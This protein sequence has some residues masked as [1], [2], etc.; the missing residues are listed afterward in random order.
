MEQKNTH[1]LTYGS[2]VLIYGNLF[3]DNKSIK[4]GI[5][6]SPGY[7]VSNVYF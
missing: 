5:L 3:T 2:L 6:S 4:G 7:S 1:H